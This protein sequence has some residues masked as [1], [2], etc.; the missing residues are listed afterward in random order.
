MVAR[1]NSMPVQCIMLWECCCV[2]AGDS[3]NVND[4]GSQCVAIGI[5]G[6]VCRGSVVCGCGC[7][8]SVL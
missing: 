6:K 1:S 5:E 2:H 7:A 3:G 4:S 8:A